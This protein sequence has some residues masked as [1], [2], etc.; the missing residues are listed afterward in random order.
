[1]AL[2]ISLQLNRDDGRLFSTEGLGRAPVLF[3]NT[4]AL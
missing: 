3:F 2:T 4:H 1:M